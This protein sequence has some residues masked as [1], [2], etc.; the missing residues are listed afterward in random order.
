MKQ[1]KKTSVP[2]D[3]E[4]WPARLLALFKAYPQSGFKAKEIAHEINLPKN[5][6]LELRKQLRALVRSGEIV[7]LK[8]NRFCLAAPA[9]EICGPLRVNS[10]GFGFVTAP[11]GQEIFINSRSMGQALHKDKV[12]VRLLAGKMGNHPEGQVLEVVERARNKIV[13]TF[14]RARCYA[15]VIPDDIKIQKDIILDADETAELI[16]GQKVVVTIEA[17]EHQRLNPLGKIVEVL[18]LADEPGVDVLSIVHNYDLAAEFPDTVHQAAEQLTE[19]ASEQELRQRL[20]LRK[21]VTFTIDPEDAKDFD[22]AVS[23]EPLENGR[24]RL[25]VHI[26]DVSYYVTENSIIDREAQKRGTSIYLVDRVIPMLP[27]KLSTRLCSLTPGSDKLCYSVLME[28][29]DHGEMVNYEF[30]HTL[31][32]S[33][34]RFS[35]E[36]AQQVLDGSLASPFKETLLNMFRLSKKLI[37]ARQKRG[38][39]DF[40][41]AEIKVLLNEAGKPTQ[42]LRRTRL[43]THRLIEEF[44]LLANRTVAEHIGK[45]LVEKEKQELAF[46]YRVHDK[47]KRTDVDDLMALA[48]V[49]GMTV[50]PAKR[51]SSHFFQRV[52]EQFKKHPAATVLQDALLRTMMKAKYSTENHGHFGLAYSFY[53]HFTSP[54]RRYPDL[55]VHRL[56]HHYLSA[57]PIAK[58]KADLEKQCQQASENEVRAQEAERASIKM[59]QLEFLETHLGEIHSGFISRIVSF[60]FFVTLPEF[61]IDGLVHIRDLHDDYYIYEPKKARLKGERRG[62]AYSLGDAVRVQIIKIDRNERLVD[63]VLV[64]KETRGKIKAGKKQ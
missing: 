14:H 1:K 17:W 28:V 31:I 43:D 19:F 21:T 50:A 41:T 36:E 48:Q 26:A 37:A 12:R 16:D 2:S 54:I 33:H 59:K 42:L 44:M 52:A 15:Y 34:K 3:A 20:D 27:E 62:G 45:F 51:I 8:K 29:T 56:L 23:L 35:Y 58:N 53:T 63:F 49:F 38:S 25:G 13:G 46:V 10:Q 57:G 39:I 55:M 5:D 7:K 4:A 24:W 60:G 40:D 61:L 22:D 18:G 9:A 32:N 30:K 64:G 11:D 47:P 6:Y